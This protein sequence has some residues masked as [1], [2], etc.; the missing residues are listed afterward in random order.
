MRYSQLPLQ[1]PG[2]FCWRRG[3]IGGMDDRLPQSDAFDLMPAHTALD[4]LTIRRLLILTAGIAVGLSLFA[5]H[6]DESGRSGADAWREL[7][8]AVI[9]GLALPAPL[10]CIPR[11]FSSHRLGTGGLFALATGLGIWL[12]LP[13]AVLEWINSNVSHKSNQGV[14]ASCLYIVLPLTG[15]WYLLAAMIIG[16]AARKQMSLTTW[17]DRYGLFLAFL[18]SPLGIWTLVDIYRDVLS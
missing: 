18:W 16:Y 6:F 5:P 10:F 17:T 14:T 8:N 13:A 9:I 7:A 2:L 4:R 15:L 1:S 3:K 11:A 12:L